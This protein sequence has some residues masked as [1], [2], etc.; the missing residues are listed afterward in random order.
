MEFLD[1]SAVGIGDDEVMVVSDCEQDASLPEQPPLV[2]QNAVVGSPERPVHPAPEAKEEESPAAEE[3][4]V[5]ITTGANDET[6]KFDAHRTSHFLTYPQTDG[7]L[8]KEILC[9]VL[10]ARYHGSFEYVIIGQENHKPTATDPVGGLHLHAYLKFNKKERIRSWTAFDVVVN[11]RTFHPNIKAVRKGQK[12]E[13]G[14][15]C[16]VTKCRNVLSTYEVGGYPRDYCKRK[17][18]CLEFTRDYTRP[19]PM[20]WPV[21]FGAVVDPSQPGVPM[22][23]EWSPSQKQRILWVWGPAGWGKTPLWNWL[24]RNHAGA[25][26]L[27]PSSGNPHHF[28]ENWNHQE[29]VIMDDPDPQTLVQE[30]FIQMTTSTIVARPVYGSP[31][32]RQVMMRPR[33]QVVFLVFA[34]APPP[35][36]WLGQERFSQRVSVVECFGDKA[37]NLDQMIADLDELAKKPE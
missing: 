17:A 34:N 33:E 19:Q 30:E 16:Y 14:V 7:I 18:D 1:E 37:A 28:Y 2:R 24:F 32:Y 20:T 26:F 36:V 5:D 22:A 23:Y 21:L 10:K 11:G 6:K 27:R 12:N 9:S 31:R 4:G 25:I 13:D 15:I 29:V 35:C 8:T 3:D